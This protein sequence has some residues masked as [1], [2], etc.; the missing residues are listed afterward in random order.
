MNTTLNMKC[1]NQD[2]KMLNK[3]WKKNVDVYFCGN[4]NEDL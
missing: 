2:C 4:L 1:F 3:L